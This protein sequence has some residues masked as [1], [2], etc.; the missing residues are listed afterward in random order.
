MSSKGQSLIE[1]MVALGVAVIIIT[2]IV[3]SVVLA[4]VNTQ[5]AKTQNLATFYAKQGMEFLRQSSRSDWSNFKN[6]TGS[7]CLARDSTELKEKVDVCEKD[8]NN[9]FRREINIAPVSDECVLESDP[10]GQTKGD[11]VEV[12]VSWNDGR[13]KDQSSFCHEVKLDS[14]LQNINAVP[15]P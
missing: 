11:K 12:V 7:Y 3:M 14:C 1:V 4:I 5:F 15:T 13:C 2:A 9:H 10:S 6:K 8:V